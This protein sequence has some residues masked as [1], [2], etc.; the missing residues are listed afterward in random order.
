MRLCIIEED[1]RGLEPLVQTRPAF[2]LRCGYYTLGDKLR[3]LCR[4]AEVG[5]WCRPAVAAIAAASVDG[6]V[7][8]AHWLLAGPALVI[9]ADW[10]PPAAATTLAA[11]GTAGDGLTRYPPW[12]GLCDGEPVYAWLY[13]SQLAV[14][15]EEGLAAA[16]RRWRKTL[17]QRPLGGVRLRYLWELVEHN[18]AE[19]ARDARL[20][21]D[22]LQPVE[23]HRAV[24]LAGVHCLGSPQMASIHPTATI[25]PGVVID[26]RG[27]PVIID[28][29]AHI[30][31]F[32]RLE[33]P[34]VIGAA[35]IVYGA[36]IRA[37]TTIGPHCRIGGEVEQ[38]VVV[39]FTNKYHQGFLGHSYVGE[40]VNLAAGTQT[41]DLRC[42]YACV[43]VP[44]AG[45]ETATPCRK[46]GAFIG[47]HAKT[48]LAVSFDAGSVV[49]PFA[50]VLPTGSY[51]P[52]HVP[53]FCRVSP[54]GVKFLSDIERLLT[55]ARIVM[56][57]RGQTLRPEAE[58]L[59]R[60]LAVEASRR[61][62]AA[63]A[64]E[65]SPAAL[66]LRISA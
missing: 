65:P 13:P 40:W 10:L 60:Q 47:D 54:R 22:S 8:D 32:S 44:I 33:G 61:W 4:I 58:Q 31:A 29:G 30:Q 35:S 24:H 52:R 20:L 12:V 14:V 57:R 38:A 37:G 26:T 18:P 16:C 66:K 6:P 55:T 25:E 50:Q 28:A 48:G 15:A 53:A 51:A 42:D 9:R 41:S 63:G 23:D 36:A 11:G 1:V 45:Q 43:S 34:C 49:E 7:N 46:V 64:V 39:G 59:Y 27:G 56:E 62:A 2:A 17:P 21:P 3:R 19:I 5:Y